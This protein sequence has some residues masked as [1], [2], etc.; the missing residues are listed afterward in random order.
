[1]AP[2]FA[3]FQAA[4]AA[5]DCG[6]GSTKLAP[7]LE[8]SVGFQAA[9]P[10]E[11]AS[12][13][14]TSGSRRDR[15]RRTTFARSHREIRRRK[16]GRFVGLSEAADVADLRLAQDND[17]SRAL[18]RFHRI[19]E[20]VSGRDRSAFVLRYIEGIEVSEVAAA[21]G[22]SGPTARRCFTRAWTRVSLLAKRDPVLAE[23]RG[24]LKCQAGSCGCSPLI[25]R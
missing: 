19:R 5:D 4:E 25:F 10:F 21:L 11:R 8:V 22:V 12:R 9:R 23:S 3:V 24:A 7:F 1:M 6:K 18:I 2:G 20:R 14:S 15:R 16:L 17:S 13:R